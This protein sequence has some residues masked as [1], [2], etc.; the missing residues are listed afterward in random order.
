M[1]TLFKFGAVINGHVECKAPTWQAFVSLIDHLSLHNTFIWRG[2]RNSKWKL[3]PTINRLF[4]DVPRSDLSVKA[5]RQLENFKYASRG[6]R[7]N[8]PPPLLTENEWWALGQHFGLATP[9]LDWTHSPFVAAY[10]ALYEERADSDGDRV[11]YGLHQPTVEAKCP[12]PLRLGRSDKSWP[13]L[14]PPAIEFFKPFSDE[15]HRL[16]SQNGLFSR[17]H[18]ELDIEDW[19]R[20]NFAGRQDMIM[21]KILIPDSVR[22]EGLR[23]LN[24][25]NI[26][27]LTLFPDLD[28]AAKFC[29]LNN[30]INSY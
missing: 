6:R 5:A 12:K 25:M 1:T 9:L 19:V 23:L 22:D 4:A 21:P 29:N 8:A 27:H 24:R 13:P 10:F 30:K 16:V 14:P 7:G 18:T 2:Q 17:S 26:N 20:A 28:G 15:N 11:V 3:E